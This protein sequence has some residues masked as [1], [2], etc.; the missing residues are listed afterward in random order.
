MGWSSCGWLYYY[1]KGIVLFGLFWKVDPPPKSSHHHPPKTHQPQISPLF[2]KQRKLF[3]KDRPMQDS[4]IWDEHWWMRWPKFVQVSELGKHNATMTCGGLHKETLVKL[5]PFPR[6]QYYSESVIVFWG[7]SRS[8]WRCHKRFSQG[9]E[10]KT[11]CVKGEWGV[12]KR[13]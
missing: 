13:G 10:K 4:W 1:R 3:P 12:L 11:A 7:L 9:Q 8:V 5:G 6:S 2:N